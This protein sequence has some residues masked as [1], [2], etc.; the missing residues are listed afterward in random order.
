MTGPGPG[1]SAWPSILVAGVLL[2]WLSPAPCSAQAPSGGTPGATAP[3]PALPS[4]TTPPAAGM[5]EAS[6]AYGTSPSEAL[7]LPS[8]IPRREVLEQPAGLMPQPEPAVA[9]LPALSHDH[10]GDG[11]GT[12]GSSLIWQG[13][14]PHGHSR[15][16]DGDGVVGGPIGPI[17]HLN[18]VSPHKNAVLVNGTLG[19]GPPGLHPGFYGF[20]LAFHSGYGYG[21]NGL[22]VG[23]QGGYPCYG[24]PGYPFRY[25]YPIFTPSPFFEGIGQLYYDPPVVIS[26]MMNAGDFGPYTGASAYAYTQPSGTAEAAAIGSFVPGAYSMPDTGATNAAPR[27]ANRVPGTERDLGMDIE[28]AV[29]PGGRKGMKI[30]NVLPE[31]TAAQAGLQSGDIIYAANGHVTQ[32]RGHLDWIITNAS[33]QNVLKLVVRK[34]NGLEQTVTIDIP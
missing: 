29:A 15:Y 11:S 28:P 23:T 3:S 30:V 31:S 16:E 24:G 25:G 7:G 12:V 21:G 33:P 9:G 10:F 22:G 4:P 1:S 2:A 13:Q 14:L 5:T 32:E 6:A 19:Y 17:G 20:G 26:D 8:P 18:T 34:A 27:G